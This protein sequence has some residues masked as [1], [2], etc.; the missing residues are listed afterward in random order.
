M[1]FYVIEVDGFEFAECDTIEEAY[2][3]WQDQLDNAE[4]GQI[5]ALSKVDEDGN[6]WQCLECVRREGVDDYDD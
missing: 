2:N 1:E 3:V 5:V 6:I 4:P